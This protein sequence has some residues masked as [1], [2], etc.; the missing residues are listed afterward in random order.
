M[1]I[2]VSIF[3]FDRQDHKIRI[4]RHTTKPYN[5]MQVLLI[6]DL[7]AFKFCSFTLL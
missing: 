3:S 7:P 5:R 6:D 1:V 2:L 4:M